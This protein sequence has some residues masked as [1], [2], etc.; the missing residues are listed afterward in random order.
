MLV[1]TLKALRPARRPKGQWNEVLDLP[2]QVFR[3]QY[4]LPL[5]ALIVAEEDAF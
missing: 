1:A 3:E 4:A 5:G 2:C